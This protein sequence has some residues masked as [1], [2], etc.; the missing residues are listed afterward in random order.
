M[1]RGKSSR[2]MTTSGIEYRRRDHRA[3]V[4]SGKFHVHIIMGYIGSCYRRLY[5]AVCRGLSR[6]IQIYVST[7]QL[8]EDTDYTSIRIIRT[9]TC[10]WVDSSQ[11]GSWHVSL[12]CMW[13]SPCGWMGNLCIRCKYQGKY[14]YEYPG[15][16]T[17]RI[18]YSTMYNVYSGG[19]RSMRK[20]VKWQ[21]HLRREG[22]TCTGVRVLLSATKVPVTFNQRRCVEDEQERLECWSPAE[23]RSEASQLK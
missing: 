5:L 9:H 23:A 2:A 12:S 14:L 10:A 20:V 13:T 8:D 17:S 6:E 1:Q 16:S 22:C 21:W 11:Q 19:E 4:W 7:C 18:Q 15:T 3:M